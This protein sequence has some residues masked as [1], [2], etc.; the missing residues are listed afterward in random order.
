MRYYSS[1]APAKTLQTAINTTATQIQLNNLTGLPASY[2]YTLVI[3]PD[4]VSEEIVTVT[5]IASGSILNVIR[6]EDGSSAYAH[7]IGATVKHMVTGRDLQEPQ[8][9]IAASAAVHGLT[10]TVVGTTDTQTLTNKT[11]TT[12]TIG[13]FV[14]ANHN[15]LNG[16]GGGQITAAAI[17]DFTEATQ[18]T[19]GTAIT[20][21][22]QNGIAVTYNDAAGV[23]N[24]DVNDPV[25][26]IDGDV[27]GSATM[28]NL[29]NTQINVAIQPGVIV[30]ADVNASAQIAYSKLNLTNTIVNADVNASAAIDP[31]KING[32][33]VVQS[34]TISTTAP[35]SGGGDLSTNRTLSIA[36][37]STSVKGAVQLTDSVASTSTTTAAT[38][39]S[40][41][42]AYDIAA[43]ALPAAQKGAANGVASLDAG[44]KVPQAQLPDIAITST[45]VVASQAAM[46]AL[47]AQPG[48]V[49]VRTDVNKSFILTASPAS[50]LGNWQELLTPTDSVL[51]VDG[52]TGTVTL[53][54]LYDAAGSAATKLPLAGGTMTGAINMGTNKI[55]NLGTPTASTDAATKNYVDT[56]TV[57]PSNLTGVITS[58]GNVT[59]TASQTGTGSTFVMQESPTLN[60]PNIG[61]ATA[62]S[63]NGT[64]IPSSKTLV[65]TD[66]TQYVV[67][68]QTGNAGKYLTTDGTTSSWG[69]VNA[70]PSQTGNAGKY[71]T[72]DGTT[73]SWASVTTD[74]T[75][76]IFMM[77][78]A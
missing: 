39:N 70:L 67:P 46:L 23:Y 14:N 68:S 15:H 64:S 53:S 42:T 21:G 30:N 45:S 8:N 32:T 43:A 72:T 38:P 35:L 62:T 73:A 28:T 12:P 36:D 63:I 7:V 69:T 47:T 34:R 2:P 52:R 75:A 41:K 29:G 74:P 9:H 58:V 24:F 4:A 11:L 6:A 77:M 61:V 76:D 60:T 16:T 31:S 71:L 3:D 10:G 54:D 59:S 5:G 55:T 50:T 37:A 27:A 18:D 33:A 78:G 44:G 49:A 20:G 1:V 26:S 57:A 40:V 25:L 66:S 13:S 48:D 19:V 51:S 56:V 65:A 17:S 22:T